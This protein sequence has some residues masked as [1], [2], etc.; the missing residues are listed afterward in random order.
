LALKV[1]I[2]KNPVAIVVI[3]SLVLFASIMVLIYVSTPTPPPPIAYTQMLQ[4]A[5]LIIAVSG[6]I[7]FVLER[8][9][10]HPRLKR[11]EIGLGP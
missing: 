7:V 11:S 9:L 6:T 8:R 4:S 1:R 3:G 10:S 2:V 5:G